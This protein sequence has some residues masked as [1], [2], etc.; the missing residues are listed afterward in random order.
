MDILG[1]KRRR[2]RI[3]ELE[4]Q[5]SELEGKV[6]ELEGEK[7]Q[8]GRISSSYERNNQTLMQK[9]RDLELQVREFSGGN[10]QLRSQLSAAHQDLANLKRE[11]EEALNELEKIQKAKQRSEELVRKLIA[12]EQEL[13]NL[14][15][16]AKLA[17]LVIIR[18]L[19]N[20]MD[21]YSFLKYGFHGIT[22]EEYK[23]KNKIMFP[24]YGN[25]SEAQIEEAIKRGV[26]VVGIS[27]PRADKMLQESLAALLRVINL[28]NEIAKLINEELVS[29]GAMKKVDQ[30]IERIVLRD[31]DAI[32]KE[33]I[34]YK[35]SL[36]FEEIV[37]QALKQ[38]CMEE[39]Q[40]ELINAQ[41]VKMI[42]EVIVLLRFV[43]ENLSSRAIGI[44]FP[45]FDR[46]QLGLKARLDRLFGLVIDA[47]NQN[48]ELTQALLD[49]NDKEIEKAQKEFNRY[50]VNRIE[51][52]GEAIRKAEKRSE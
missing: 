1:R 28:L 41:I 42:R 46:I 38:G 5:L 23:L 51:A 13:A 35:D 44:F 52:Y 48:G 47:I 12:T 32:Y 15:Q 6:K 7:E 49:L 10:S 24:N 8:L 19:K 4:N 45:E 14:I 50:L 21:R 17:T 43:N 3:Q 11:K 30:Y 36:K 39:K 40:L 26:R 9:I 33:Y 31:Y 2:K 22:Q 18:T 34:K 25:Y 20:V 27:L 37:I 16:K 29:T